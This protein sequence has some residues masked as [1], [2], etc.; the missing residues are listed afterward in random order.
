MLRVLIVFC[1]VVVIPSSFAGEVPSFEE[2][3]VDDLMDQRSVIDKDIGD[4]EK[5]KNTPSYKEPTVDSLVE[6]QSIIDKALM[7][8]EGL[9]KS[10]ILDEQLNSSKRLMNSIEYPK[11]GLGFEMPSYLSK[12]NDKGYLD[13][14]LNASVNSPEELPYGDFP[15]PLVLVS[16]SMPEEQILS[17]VNE[18]AKVGASVVVRG[19]IDNDLQ[20]T[21]WALKDL[22]SQVEG[23][24]LAIDPTVFKRFDI[25]SVP[26]FVL[27]FEALK[28]CDGVVCAVPSYTKAAGSVTLRYFLELVER[29]ATKEDER[30]IAKSWIAKYEL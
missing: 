5:N 14:A 25:T 20:K 22:S 6:Q 29:S 18:A 19:L 26:S 2:P 16:F 4:A 24:G 8:A 17:L 27:P 11:G 21:V 28:R 15:Q 13:R 23:G 7:E 1:F 12:L 30:A 9:A 10:G 3:T